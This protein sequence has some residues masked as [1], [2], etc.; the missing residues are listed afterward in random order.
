M[1]N[2]PTFRQPVGF[3]EKNKT[4]IKG[5]LI[6]FL[7]LLML[8]PASIIESLVRERQHRQEE[9]I[10]EV[11]NKWAK[12]QTIN[13]PMLMI[14]YHT[15]ETTK[16]GKT[17]SYRHNAYLLPEQLNITGNV[18]PETR[19]RSLYNVTLYRSSMV[20]N[21]KF[22]I[23]SLQKLNIN[24]A[25]I[26][27]NETKLVLGI[28][29]ARGL[30]EEMVVQWNGKKN[31]LETGVPENEI[32]PMG[33]SITTIPDSLKQNDFVINIKL[34]GSEYLYFTPVGNVTNVTLQ[35]SWK[36][37]A[38]DG[39]YLPTNTKILN[40]TGFT[41][42]WKILQISRNY[43]Q[44]WADSKYD[45]SA[46]S[47]GVRLISPNDNYAKTERSVKYAIL[48]ISLTFIVF[49]FLEILQKKQIHPLQ[50]LLVGFALC[51]FYTL[52]LSI[53]EYSGFNPAYIIASVAT[54]FLI[55]L[56]VWSIFKQGKL[57]IGFATALGGL[58]TY[59]F[60]LIQLQDYAL[61]FG[62]IGLFVILA[63]LMYFSRKIDWY[64]TSKSAKNNDHE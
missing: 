32:I 60:V 43:P 23:Q 61:L 31:V 42:N 51:I 50:Y 12:A 2:T 10:N 3:F 33:M 14:P 54:I 5:F 15:Y 44:V 34:K 16:E 29:D 26:L 9:V 18:L 7:I 28:N 49:F 40:D 52:L 62:S 20:I 55:G 48:F 38:F 64:D 46:S 25:N 24:P 17:I 63:T 4:I 11:S 19:H 47:F 45:L 41:A 36:D 27:W 35:S 56:Y 59:I 6:G 57:A 30:E 37:P 58:Y 21:G 8:I 1:D 53:S 13:G 39:Q 22:N